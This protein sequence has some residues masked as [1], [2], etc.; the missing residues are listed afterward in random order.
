[1]YYFL[2]FF[3]ILVLFQ[4]LIY[5][6]IVFSGYHVVAIEFAVE[7]MVE[8]SKIWIVV[9][10][11]EPNFSENGIFFWISAL[12]LEISKIS[13]EFWECGTKVDFCGSQSKFCGTSFLKCGSQKKNYVSKSKKIKTVYAGNNS[14][15]WTGWF[16][17]FFF[18]NKYRYH[19][20]G[21]HF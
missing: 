16:S 8:P 1:M 19:V 3:W 9:L 6:N 12:T 2:T 21:K 18:L 10:C 17:R 5:Q 13:Y 7:P 4:I 15:C 14:F 20:I 11:V